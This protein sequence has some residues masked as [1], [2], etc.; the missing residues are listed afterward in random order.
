MNRGFDDLAV[1]VHNGTK[2]AGDNVLDPAVVANPTYG[3]TFT[4]GVG[5]T[6]ARP[7]FGPSP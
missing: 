3:C 5:G 2:P 6:P 7:S 1:W 4:T